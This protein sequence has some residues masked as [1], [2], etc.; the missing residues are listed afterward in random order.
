M[1]KS[2]VKVMAT[3]MIVR[4]KLK[5]T[6]FLIIAKQVIRP[7]LENLYV[8]LIIDFYSPGCLLSESAGWTLVT[9]ELFKKWVKSKMAAGGHLEKNQ[10]KIYFG[11]VEPIFYLEVI[12][13]GFI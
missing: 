10:S 7:N 1:G 5:Q 9:L 11:G 12:I 6:M 8:F 3:N 2:D 13:T 4:S